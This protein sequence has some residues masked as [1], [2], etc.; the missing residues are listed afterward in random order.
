MPQL[1]VVSHRYDSVRLFAHV[2]HL[3]HDDVYP[4]VDVRD[5][6]GHRY[7]AV[8][9]VVGHPSPALLQHVR[10]EAEAQGSSVR[11]AEVGEEVVSLLGD[12]Q[13]EQLAKLKG[14][15]G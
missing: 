13:A 6:V 3:H 12:L 5:T 2:N 8:V 15:R 14:L 9:W 11:F 1:T 4:I 10:R 7:S